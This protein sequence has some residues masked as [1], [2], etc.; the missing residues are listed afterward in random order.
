MCQTIFFLQ[1]TLAQAAQ[2][3][4]LVSLFHDF[5]FCQGLAGS[6]GG[7]SSEEVEKPNIAEDIEAIKAKAKRISGNGAMP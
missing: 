5:C 1:A 3:T 6:D 4:L 7:A 2:N